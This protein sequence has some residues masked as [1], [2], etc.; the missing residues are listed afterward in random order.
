MLSTY[1]GPR[2]ASCARVSSIGIILKSMYW[3]PLFIRSNTGIVCG[4]SILTE[5][6]ICS[7]IGSFERILK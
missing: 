5:L 6:S 2:H 7:T 1:N 4:C 3:N